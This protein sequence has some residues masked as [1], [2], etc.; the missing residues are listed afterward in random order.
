M[1][2]SSSVRVPPRTADGTTMYRCVLLGVWAAL[3]TLGVLFL[4]LGTVGGVGAVLS[5]A[6]GGVTAAA[7]RWWATTTGQGT[8]IKR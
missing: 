7:T 4:M 5:L 2:S 3:M 1:A 8:R 6:T